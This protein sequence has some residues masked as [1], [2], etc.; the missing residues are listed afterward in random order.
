MLT[1]FRLCAEKERKS[2]FSG[3]GVPS[4]GLVATVALRHLCKSITVY[5]FGASVGGRSRGRGL[6]FRV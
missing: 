1:G 6:G 3:G 5:G 4:S 2:K